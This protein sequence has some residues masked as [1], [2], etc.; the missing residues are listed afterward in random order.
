MPQA[1]FDKKLV[2][3]GQG[4]S[5]GQIIKLEKKNDK[6]SFLI[7]GTPHY[8]G[9]HWVGEDRPVICNRVAQE[10]PDA[11][12]EWCAKLDAGEENPHARNK[13]YRP[14]MQF[15]YPIVNLAD[16]KP[17]IFQTGS[18]VH[19]TIKDNAEKGIDVFKSPWL[20]TR[21]EGDDPGKY[22]STLRLDPVEITPE[23]EQA[24]KDAAEFDL[25]RLAGGGKESDSV[26]EADKPSDADVDDIP[27]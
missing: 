17:A 2:I 1:D 3:P 25:E 9:K 6:V 8:V 15:Y 21:N 4:N 19:S 20:V 16:N 18:L 12:C 24:K 23:I 27:F 13:S 26:V 11:E 5:Q 22:Y 7:A 10:D 14:Q